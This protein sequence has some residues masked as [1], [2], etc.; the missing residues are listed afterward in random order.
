MAR[1]FTVQAKHLFVLLLVT[2]YASSLESCENA[3]AFG[4]MIV[5]FAVG[6]AVFLQVFVYSTVSA[7][8][9][10]SA[11]LFVSSSSILAISSVMLIVE[12]GSG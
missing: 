9:S 6:V 5:H 2:A 3:T 7:K 4:S 12:S 8:I 10:S 1:F 11:A